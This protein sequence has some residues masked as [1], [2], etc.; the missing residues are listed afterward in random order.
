MTKPTNWDAYYERPAPT[1][2]LTR[3]YT[4]NWLIKTMAQLP[5]H[6]LDIV[7]F[8]G[9]NS[10]CC[11]GIIEAL[12]VRRY[13]VVDFNDQGLRLFTAKME[14]RHIDHQAVKANLLLETPALEKADVVFS[15][16][17]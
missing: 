7:E 16:G 1:A 12:P 2:R 8:G 9:A 11:L 5:D 3:L 15:V 4:Q 10:F 13:A 6:P 17:L 14:G